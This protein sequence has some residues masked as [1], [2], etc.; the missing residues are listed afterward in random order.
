MPLRRAAWDGW[1]NRRT[2]LASRVT[3]PGSGVSANSMP[4]EAPEQPPAWTDIRTPTE[5][6]GLSPRNSWN[7]LRARS[8]TVM[9][10][11]VSILTVTGAAAGVVVAMDSAMDAFE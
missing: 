7:L 1:T 4:Y 5:V 10:R 2:P 11:V 9:V 3:S 8:V 6:R